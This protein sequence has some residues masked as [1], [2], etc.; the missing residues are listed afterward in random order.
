MK[1]RKRIQRELANL[2]T[3]LL[4]T[5]F[6]SFIA[7]NSIVFENVPDYIDMEQV[8]KWIIRHGAVTWFYD[9]V[10]EKIMC[11][12]FNVTGKYD[13]YNN[14][15]TITAYANN[16]YMRQLNYNDCVIMYDNSNKS[17]IYPY[18][19]QFAERLALNRRVEDINIF[20]QKTPRI[21]KCSENQKMTLEKILTS[22]DTFNTD[23]LISDLLN[24]DEMTV[25]FNPVPFVADKINE[26]G[27]R[28]ISEFL[29]LL[30]ICSVTDEKK[31]RLISSEIYFSQGGALVA[32]RGRL[33]PRE[34]AVDEIN[35]KYGLDIKVKFYDE[36]GGVTDVTMGDMGIFSGGEAREST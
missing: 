31:E 6:L 17:S 12:P 19:L 1:S 9:D 3:I 7:E 24:L 16:G 32:R 36:I 21:F 34:Q 25:E 15:L 11:L 28:V 14:P 5:D 23:I 10:L 35:K 2:D 26:N 27:N 29:Q 22:L 8:N 4:Y 33:S 20:N 18:V 30:G 13:V